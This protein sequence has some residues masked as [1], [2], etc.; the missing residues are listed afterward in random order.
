MEFKY[1]NINQFNFFIPSTALTSNSK[2]INIP[3]IFRT[4]KEIFFCKII[5]FPF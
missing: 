2:I 1:D 3:K 5:K 4:P